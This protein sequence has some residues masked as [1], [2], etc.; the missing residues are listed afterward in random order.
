MLYEIQ[1]QLSFVCFCFCAHDHCV[2]DWQGSGTAL[3]GM[4]K[5]VANTT[6]RMM[7]CGTSTAGRCLAVSITQIANSAASEFVWRGVTAIHGNL[8]YDEKYNMYCTMTTDALLHHFLCLFNV[9]TSRRFL[10]STRILKGERGAT[11]RQWHVAFISFLCKCVVP[12][13]TWR[14]WM[15]NLNDSSCMSYLAPNHINRDNSNHE[16]DPLPYG[17]TTQWLDH[18]TSITEVMG[19]ISLKSQLLWR[20]LKLL[21]NCND[22][23]I[24]HITNGHIQYQPSQKDFEEWV[25]CYGE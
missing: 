16:V 1:V 7:E 3:S 21:H 12:E 23:Y 14:M 17:F 19:L 8:K 5:H 4:T 20:L 13:I 18:H 10:K 24:I 11:K 9:E 6:E 25:I 2:F 22:H 15:M